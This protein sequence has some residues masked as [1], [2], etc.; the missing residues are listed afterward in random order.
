MTWVLLL[1]IK[2]T[3]TG[4]I[5]KSIRRQTNS[6]SRMRLIKRPTQPLNRDVRVDLRRR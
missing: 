1:P 6:R 3:L 4:P 5:P 2:M